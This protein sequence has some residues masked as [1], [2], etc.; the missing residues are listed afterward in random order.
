MRKRRRK[1]NR[2]ERV[3]DEGARRGYGPRVWDAI[4]VV[5]SSN[6]EGSP[7]LPALVGRGDAEQRANTATADIYGHLEAEQRVL[8]PHRGR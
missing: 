2:R 1:P 8:R 4:T 6:Q 5:I 7:A 3:Q